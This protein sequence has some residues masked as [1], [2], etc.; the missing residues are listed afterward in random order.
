MNNQDNVDKEMDKIKKELLI[1]LE[2]NLLIM[3]L[4]ILDSQSEN[5]DYIKLPKE[6]AK[7]ISSVLEVYQFM[8]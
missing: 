6:M 2:C 7:R 5:E 3:Q 8:E 4:Y 1:S